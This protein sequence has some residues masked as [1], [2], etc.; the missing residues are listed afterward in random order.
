[1]DILQ[2]LGVNFTTGNLKGGLDWHVHHYVETK[3]RFH[4]SL[5]GLRQAYMIREEPVVVKRFL[6][7]YDYLDV[8]EVVDFYAGIKTYI[9]EMESDDWVFYRLEEVEEDFNTDPYD[10]Y[11]DLRKVI[12][13][14]ALI[15]SDDQ[16]TTHEQEQAL[17]YYKITKREFDLA[18]ES[19]EH[20]MRRFVNE[21]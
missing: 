7:P 13:I 20:T 17:H 1:M 21:V 3:A 12:Y 6:F 2:E 9:S 19:L 8:Q 16:P 18:R 11:E 10:D 14:H 5:H 4:E 15:K